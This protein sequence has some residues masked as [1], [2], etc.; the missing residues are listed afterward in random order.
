MPD[1]ELIEYVCNENP[2]TFT[3]REQHWVGKASDIKKAEVQVAPEILAK[4]AG[5]Y[6]ELDIW[7]GGPMPRTIEVTVSDGALFAEVKGR[8]KVQL[9]ALSQTVFTGFYG[10]G[11]RF[12]VDS[13]G[14]VT[15]LAEQHVSGDY[16]FIRLK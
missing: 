7:N 3:T 11:L 9:S 1:T 8:G 12:I 4:Y 15:H 10:L 5:T 6:V 14:V 2:K 16:R 13:Q